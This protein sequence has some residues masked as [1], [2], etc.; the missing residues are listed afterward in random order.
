MSTS[1]YDPCLLITNSD[2]ADAFGIVSMQIDD[3]LILRTTAFS[4]LK[5]EKLKKVYF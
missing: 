3:T 4:S 2:D 5:E 1:T